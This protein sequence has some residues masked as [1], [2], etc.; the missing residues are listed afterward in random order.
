MHHLSIGTTCTPT[1]REMPNPTPPKPNEDFQQSTTNHG[2]NSL[3]AGDTE[4][5]TTTRPT[6]VQLLKVAP[7]GHRSRDKHV[8]ALRRARANFF[9]Q[10]CCLTGNYLG[11]DVGLRGCK[12]PLTD[13]TNLREL[14]DSQPLGCLTCR[15]I[16]NAINEA[17]IE[18]RQI[19]GFQS[20]GVE[21]W[22]DPTRPNRLL[23][24]NRCTPGS[25][26]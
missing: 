24:H 12:H 26:V 10:R 23:H 18:W 14:C 22:L 2:I 7:P 16:V 21:C 11:A 8:I 6:Q 3:E 17:V 9:K 15:A 19:Q 25:L 5:C 1:R 4:D 20:V 13:T